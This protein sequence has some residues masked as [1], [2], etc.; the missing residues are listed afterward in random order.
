MQRTILNLP[1]LFRSLSQVQTI[2]GAVDEC[3]NE[4]CFIVP[5]LGDYGDR[6]VLPVRA[7]RP[8]SWSFLEYFFKLVDRLKVTFISLVETA[9]TVVAHFPSP[10]A[11][12]QPS[13][14]SPKM[15]G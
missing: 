7:K 3:L 12:L 11:Q 2:T 15:L 1:S 5:G 9:C 6:E 10:V 14:N 13:A 4:H 8:I